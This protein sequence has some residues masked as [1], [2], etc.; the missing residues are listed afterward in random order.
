[1]LTQADYDG[2]GRA[3]ALAMAGSG[4]VAVP[5]LCAVCGH[6]MTVNG[7]AP[8]GSPAYACPVCDKAK[9]DVDRALRLAEIAAAGKP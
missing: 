9:I 3:V 1:M 6:P 8:V 5:P 2:I 7:C 4:T